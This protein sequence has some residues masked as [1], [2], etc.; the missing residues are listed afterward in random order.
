LN[1]GI[2]NTIVFSNPNATGY[3]PGL[4][5]ITVSSG[6]NTSPAISPAAGSFTS[7]QTVTITDT[8]PGAAIFY[9]TNGA[10]PTGSST[11]Y[12]G[13]ITVA[14]SET[15]QAI[16]LASGYPDSS[17]ASA[18]Y[19]V[20]LPAA[21]APSFTPGAGTYTSLQSVTLSDTTPAASIYYTTDGTTPTINS[22]LYR[23]AISISATQTI[24]AIAVATG[25]ISSSVSS[26]TYTIN[27]PPPTIALTLSPTTLTLARGQ[28]GTVSITVT[29]QNGFNGVVTFSCSGIP[30]GATCSFNPATV[31]PTGSTAT[32]TLT[33][34]AGTSMATAQDHS[35]PMISGTTLAFTLCLLGWRKQ[36]GLRPLLLMS[37][38]VF[39]LSLLSACSTSSRQPTTSTVTVTATSS[40]VQQ[41]VALTLTVQ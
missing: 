5:N 20:N 11:P 4:D 22:S 36:R 12:S 21:A 25:Y 1:G 16:A 3:A 19:I 7:T 6:A 29:P 23:A 34:A 40:S 30:R 32:T 28:Q 38:S 2:A 27:L 17:I 9:T 39:S 8:T 14:T 35:I 33:I 10:T 24:Q 41:S 18:A 26:A 13:P 15:I 37:A 31:T